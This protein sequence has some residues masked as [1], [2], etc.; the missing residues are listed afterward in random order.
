MAALAIDDYTDTPDEDTPDELLKRA[1]KAVKRARRVSDEECAKIPALLMKAVNNRLAELAPD[2]DPRAAVKRLATEWER[3][4]IE[5]GYDFLIE[6]YETS[7]R[8]SKQLPAYELID[9]EEFVW[10]AEGMLRRLKDG[11][12]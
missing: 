7:M 9:H 6:Y 8:S 1:Q 5:S 10:V 2:E 11:N 3:D 4:S 12:A